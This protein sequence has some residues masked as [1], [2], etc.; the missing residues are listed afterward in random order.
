MELNLAKKGQKRRTRYT[1]GCAVLLAEAQS[2]KL[3][4]T[5][6]VNVTEAWLRKALEFEP[7]RC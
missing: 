3:L 1:S 2:R 4:A 7:I 6:G 5:Y